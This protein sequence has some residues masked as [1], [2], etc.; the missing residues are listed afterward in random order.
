MIGLGSW[1]FESW[2]IGQIIWTDDAHGFP[3]LEHLSS[4]YQIAGKGIWVTVT[5]NEF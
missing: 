2:T 4:V 1:V 5:E 3:I